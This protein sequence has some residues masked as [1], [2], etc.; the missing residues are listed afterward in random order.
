MK[1]Y[2]SIVIIFLQ[3]LSGHTAPWSIRIPCVQQRRVPQ[4]QPGRCGWSEVPVRQRYIQQ[5]LLLLHLVLQRAES[6]L[7]SHL[8]GHH[9]YAGGWL[10]AQLCLQSHSEGKA[11]T[12]LP[13]SECYLGGWKHWIRQAR[14][15]AKLRRGKKV[16]LDRG[17]LPRTQ[18]CAG[19][20]LVCGGL[21]GLCNH[22]QGH[23]LRVHRWPW[24][25]KQGKGPALLC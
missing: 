18:L 3:I 1:W 10:G 11:A 16:S 12:Q 17:G 13:L 20:K 23:N 15:S 22:L 8:R 4:L 6:R 9:E 25:G 21:R 14:S 2:N 7:H 5:V 19:Y 24:H